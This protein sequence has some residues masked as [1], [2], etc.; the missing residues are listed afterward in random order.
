[1]MVELRPT[2]VVVTM[3][4]QYSHYDNRAKACHDEALNQC[5]LLEATE[6]EFAPR[7]LKQKRR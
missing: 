4:N 1:M 2:T 3:I 6:G 7:L 5:P